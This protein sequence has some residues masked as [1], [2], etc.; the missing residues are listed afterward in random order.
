MQ[1]KDLALDSAGKRGKRASW[2]RVLA[3]RGSLVHLKEAAHALWRRGRIRT[4]E[5]SVTPPGVGRNPRVVVGGHH[6]TVR[7]A[8]FN[9]PAIDA[10]VIGE[11][12]FTMRELLAQR[13]VDR[14]LDSIPGLALPGTPQIR[15]GWQPPH[16]SPHAEDHARHP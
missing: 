11:G 7:P 9:S 5:S 4:R 13:Q 14:P 8:D 10:V 16:P 1:P 6:A 3:C 15:T 12:V 2:T